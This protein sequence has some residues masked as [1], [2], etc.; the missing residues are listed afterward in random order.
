MILLSAIQDAGGNVKPRACCI[1]EVNMLTARRAAMTAPAPAKA[2]GQSSWQGILQILLS[3][4]Y[5]RIYTRI[6][7]KCKFYGVRVKLPHMP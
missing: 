7:G 2:S 3:I 5:I 6:P 4:R 1:Q